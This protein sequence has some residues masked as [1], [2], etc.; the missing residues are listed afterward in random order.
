MNPPE[1]NHQSNTPAPADHGLSALR[2]AGLH[3]YIG[4]TLRVSARHLPWEIAQQ[5][6]A[7]HAVAEG[8]DIPAFHQ[9][10]L[11]I[12]ELDDFSWRA[13]VTTSNLAAAQALGWDAMRRL[14]RLA[15][16]YQCEALEFAI[17]YL[18]LPAVLECEVFPW[19]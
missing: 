13:D 4:R 6:H 17:D 11:R 5:L 8:N 12:V 1:I 10:G 3:R 2:T 7:G 18:V 9:A 19:P 14:L 16:T 15:Q